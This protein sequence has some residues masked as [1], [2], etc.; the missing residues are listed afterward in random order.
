MHIPALR[1]PEVEAIMPAPLRIIATACKE[2]RTSGREIDGCSQ[3]SRFV[4]RVLVITT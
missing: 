1:Q 3:R 4:L 2:P